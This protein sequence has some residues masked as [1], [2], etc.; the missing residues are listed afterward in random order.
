MTAIAPQEYQLQGKHLKDKGVVAASAGNHAL[1]LAYHGG[2]M[3][4]PITVIMPLGASMTKVN[5]CK[6]MGEFSRRSCCLGTTTEACARS[7][8][9]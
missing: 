4:I 1:G 3:G 5:R 8:T 7:F 9:I 6:D 2:K